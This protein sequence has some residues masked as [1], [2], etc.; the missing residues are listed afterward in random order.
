MARKKLHLNDFK[1]KSISPEERKNTKGGYKITPVEFTGVST[2]SWTEV[3]I[4]IENLPYVSNDRSTKFRK[5]R[6]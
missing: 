1:K 2:I 6:P 3:D 5:K 4:R